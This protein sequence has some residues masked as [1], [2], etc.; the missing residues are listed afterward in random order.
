MVSG[1]VSGVA[2]DGSRR[3]GVLGIL[4]GLALSLVRPAQT[5]NV[6]VLEWARHYPEGNQAGINLTELATD[7]AGNVYLAG[8]AAGEGFYSDFALVSYAPDGTTRWTAR[9]PGTNHGV[10]ASAL[11]VDSHGHV[12]VTGLTEGP[13]GRNAEWTTLCYSSAGEFQWASQYHGSS[14][15][16]DPP[17]DLSVDSD[18]NVVLTGASNGK[19]T[20]ISY[21]PEGVQRWIARY[22]AD[23]LVSSEG[24]A[25]TVDPG[26]NVFVTGW[27]ENYFGPDGG[28]RDFV[29]LCYSP[30]GTQRWSALFRGAPYWNVAPTAIG[31]DHQ[32]NAYIAGSLPNSSGEFEYTTISYAPDGAERWVARYHSGA[33]VN[34]QA[35]GLVIDSQDNVYTTGTFVDVQ[36]SKITTVSYTSQGSE[37]WVRRFD[38]PQQLGSGVRR[39]TVD[40][41]DRIYL[42][43]A[44]A[45]SQAS[46]TTLPDNY[47]LLVLSYTSTGAE[48]WVGR[49]EGA[50]RGND[51]ALSLVPDP[52]GA[53]YV[54]GGSETAPPQYLQ[55]ALL[56]FRPDAPDTTAPA[57][58]I[59]ALVEG[60]G[61]VPS[62]FPIRITDVDSGIAQVQ[63][64]SKSA[65]CELAWDGPTGVVTT[66]IGRTLKFSPPVPSAQLRVIR[67][68]GPR[69]CWVNLRALDGLGN[70]STRY[71]GVADIVGGRNIHLTRVFNSL[72]QEEHF[73]S[74][75]NGTPGLSQVTLRVNRKPIYRG[76]FP[77]GRV[78]ELDLSN[79]YRKGNRNRVDLVA[80]ADPGTT[81]R[82]TLGAF[83]PNLCSDPLQARGLT[84]TKPTH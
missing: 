52:N 19:L 84:D 39:I 29:T 15:H 51:E 14:P 10:G 38:G 23:E 72:P 32:G 76:R 11:A 64:T 4:L 21:T 34:D 42:A 41:D 45:V 7:A 43:G 56:K 81:A 58:R 49:Y 48:R 77:D 28:R 80:K 53:L 27:R 61:D 47:D 62:Y 35:A 40:G 26:G 79:F 74:L 50:N 16:D 69:E 31:L 57:T 3:L 55:S 22:A 9:Y 6:G 70:A 46:S 13:V 59:G 30:T 1:M 18:G 60:V 25:L 37:R 66:R 63:L 12:Y 24:K 68:K 36:Y 20:T 82:L 73:I 71:V 54:L 44:T 5:S 78:Y 65:N 67:L 17:V 33:Q 83:D 75:R 2:R 8:R